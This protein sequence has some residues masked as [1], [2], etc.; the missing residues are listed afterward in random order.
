[1]P[2]VFALLNAFLMIALPLA[3]IIFLVRRF[4]L[5]WRIIIVGALTFI[6]SQIVHI[7]LLYGLTF[8]FVQVP[9]IPT[10]WTIPFN[11]IVLGLMAGLC[12]EIARYVAY[13]WAIPTA[14][15]WPQAL[16][17]GAG[18]GG[19]EAIIFGVIA[20]LGALQ[21]TVLHNTDPSQW[22][23]PA[24]QLPLVQ[25]QVAT[26]WSSPWY[27]FLL[28][29]L[30][31]VFAL[32]IHLSAAVLVLQVFTRK[33]IAWLLAAI[34]WHALVDGLT[35][36]IQGVSNPYWTEL[37]IGATALI[38]LGIVFALRDSGRDNTSDNAPTPQ[39]EHAP[40]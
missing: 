10:S 9:I 40:N 3:L 39:V 8:F 34:A 15:T 32:C 1:M 37:C 19:I 18:H 12:E 22:G 7:P 2:T 11:A 28:G 24:A 25:Q 27:S 5:A 6:A 16:G 29:A 17:F 30:E 14:R 23:V 35:V 31:R 38:S 13:R 20:G 26:F 33:N 4:H 36:Y 21:L